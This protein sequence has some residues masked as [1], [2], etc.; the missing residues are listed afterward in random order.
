Y[1]EGVL[2]C[3]RLVLGLLL[4]LTA[5]P[6]AQTSAPAGLPPLPFEDIGACP[7]EGCSYREWIARESVQIRRDR[8]S[9]SPVVFELAAGEVVTAVTGTV[10]T[11]VPGILRVSTPVTLESL[12]GVLAVSPQD[13]VYL[14][15]YEG[16]GFYKAWF[17]GRLHTGVDVGQITGGGCRVAADCAG[18]IVAEPTMVWWVQVR[19]AKGQVGWTDRPE[20]FDNKDA[21]A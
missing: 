17:R 2:R 6:R 12:Y 5:G 13:T 19:N 8:A 18:R 15:T 1:R 3:Q 4:L 21:L 16:E 14:L 20:L 9:S 11:V 7:F 10:V